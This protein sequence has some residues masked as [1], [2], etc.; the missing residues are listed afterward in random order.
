MSGDPTDAH[1]ADLRVKLRAF[2]SSMLQ[3]VQRRTKLSRQRLDAFAASRV[4]RS[5]VA[6]VQ[7][8]RLLL[9]Y[10][11]KS[12]RAGADGAVSKARQRYAA[13][14]AG[15]DAMSPLKVLRRGY[16]VALTGQGQVVKSIRQLQPGAGITLRLCDGT[17]DAVIRAVKEERDGTVEKL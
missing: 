2:E 13:L 4:L 16:S 3:S 14:A 17:A 6:Y 1:V 15:L 11:S 9:D 8:R 5:P 10:L 7:D 12:L